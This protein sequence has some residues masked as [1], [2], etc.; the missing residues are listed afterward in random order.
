MSAK[1]DLKRLRQA[2]NEYL[3]AQNTE[4][5]RDGS[6]YDSERCRKARVRLCRTVYKL[7]AKAKP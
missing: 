7:N 2:V 3:L 5:Y 1:R 6:E 4:G